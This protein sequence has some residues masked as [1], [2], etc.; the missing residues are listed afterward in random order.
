MELFTLH[1][2]VMDLKDRLQVIID[3][4]IYMYM[5]LLCLNDFITVLGSLA[6]YF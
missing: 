4:Y 3:I 6:M 5:I 1:K 2:E